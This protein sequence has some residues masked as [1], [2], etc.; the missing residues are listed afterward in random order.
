MGRFCLFS[1]IFQ[2]PFYTLVFSEWGC[3]FF[4]S[5]RLGRGDTKDFLSLSKKVLVTLIYV[6]C[7]F[8]SAARRTNQ[9]APPQLSDLLARRLGRRRGLR[10]SLRS[11]SSRPFFS[12][13]LAP[14]PPDKGGIGVCVLACILTP[15]P[16]GHSPYIPCRNTGGED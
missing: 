6:I 14:S 15:S 10:N 9:E 7:S 3:F 13:S 4:C 2:L 16:F 11:D 8:F 1:F 5:V 12:V